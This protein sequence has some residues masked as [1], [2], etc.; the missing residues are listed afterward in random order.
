MLSACSLDQV[1]ANSV[2][3]SVDSVMPTLIRIVQPTK[4]VLTCK[5]GFENSDERQPETENIDFKEK[6]VNGLPATIDDEQIH[7]AIGK[8]GD[9]AGAYWIVNRH[10]GDMRGASWT[11]S[12]VQQIRG[13]CIKDDRKF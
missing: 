9:P 13:D 6:T 4:L 10:S 2:A 8:I 12:S 11:G 5:W 3:D 1:I 7:W